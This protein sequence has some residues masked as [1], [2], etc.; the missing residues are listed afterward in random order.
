MTFPS[1]RAGQGLRQH[2]DPD[3]A[4]SRARWLSTWLQQ[5]PKMFRESSGFPRS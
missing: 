1:H 3:L 2:M 5:L 4:H